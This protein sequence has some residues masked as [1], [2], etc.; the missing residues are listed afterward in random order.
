MI[1]SFNLFLFHM[2][3]LFF[4]DETSK[5]KLPETNKRNL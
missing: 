4:K 5:Q 2:H 3:A 1:D